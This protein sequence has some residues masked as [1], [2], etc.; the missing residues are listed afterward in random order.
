[1]REV[2]SISTAVRVTR[3]T[4]EM[5]SQPPS[6]LTSLAT[7]NQAQ[8]RAVRSEASTVAILAG[9]GSG[10][11]HTLASRVVWLLDHVGY[12]PEDIVVTTF[13]VKAAREMKDRIGKAL[14]NGKETKLVLGTF[15][16]IAR[17]Y[18]AAYGLRIGVNQRFAIADDADSRAIIAR[19]CKRLALSLE[20]AVI[21]SWISKQKAKGRD[22]DAKRQRQGSGP[23]ESPDL[24][25]AYVE[26]QAHLERSNLLDYDD[27]LVK[28]VELLELHPS[29]VSNVQAVL[30]DEFQDTNGIQYQLMKLLAQKHRRITIVGDPDQSIYGWRSAE[31]KNLSRLLRDFPGTFEVSLEQNYRSSHSIVDMA[32]RVIEQDDKRYQKKLLSTHGRG[33]RPVLRRLKTPAL[34]AEWIVSELRRCL[35]MT[36][37]MLTYRDVAVLLRSA[38]LSRHVEAHLGR[39]G[40]SYRMVGGFKFYERLEVKVVLDYL[41]VICQ[42]SNNDAVARVINVPRRGIGE[43]TIKSLV[44]EAEKAGNS[45]WDL[46]C[47]HCRGDRQ[48]KTKLTKQ[49]EQ[50]IGGL[51]RMISNLQRNM[52]ATVDQPLGLVE[53]LE[54]P[55]QRQIG[56]EL[57]PDTPLGFIKSLEAKLQKKEEPT[58]DRSLG[59]VELLEAL[60]SPSCLNFRK[61]LE[62]AYPEEHEQRWANVQEFMAMVDDFSRDSERLEDEKLPQIDGIE[63]AVQPTILARFLANVSLASDPD[64]T[65][66]RTKP[67]QPQV[68]ISTIHAA[69]GL[70]WPIVFIPSAHNG[71]IPHMRSEDDDEERRLLY[72]AMTRAKALLYLSCPLYTSHN[73]GAQTELS[74]F[75]EPISGSFE[76][77]GPSFGQQTLIELT[78]ILGRVQAPSQDSIYKSLPPMFAPEDN[79]FPIDPLDNAHGGLARADSGQAQVKR[80][81]RFGPGREQAQGEEAP[82]KKEYATTMEQSSNFTEEALPGFTTANAHQRVLA[83]L[84]PEAP[85]RGGKA[86]KLG[87]KRLSKQRSLTEFSGQGFRHK[88]PINVPTAVPGRTQPQLQSHTMDPALTSHSL[89]GTTT[90]SRPVVQ[91]TD[92]AGGGDKY[93]NFSSSPPRPTG[94]DSENTSPAPEPTRPAASFHATTCTIPKSSLGAFK[95]P[96]GLARV[97][98]APMEKLR[99]PF[100]PLTLNRS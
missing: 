12:A 35:A 84:P 23:R 63:Q 56:K 50:K 26:Y 3:E 28:A 1:M 51:I 82:W 15:H 64:K 96:T 43:G 16:S 31:Q 36:G 17:R 78:K 77:Q 45:L 40:I 98:I 39:A 14:G 62:D 7:L 53:S 58:K 60:L 5:P 87:A 6:S 72:V 37:G 93:P 81:R 34:E 85:A 57:T 38:S 27:L 59:L 91:R 10:K 20:P 48:A 9:P 73:D 21:R 18:L 97:G 68:T 47:R 24:Q 65:E 99:K 44:D 13:T 75:L 94:N 89:T 4:R 69:K 30:I 25:T 49:A 54:A 83:T 61:Y 11:T 52:E 19:I 79:L 92:S 41:R 29:C 46:L 66:D 100:K 33:T 86:V 2:G 22:G 88:R 32:L 70:E 42:T 90:S 8:C 55:L 71:S 74:P 76:K 67:N 95:R 80:Q